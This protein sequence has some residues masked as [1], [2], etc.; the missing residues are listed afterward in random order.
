MRELSGARSPV[1]IARDDTTYPLARILDFVDRLQL[2]AT[3]DTD[4]L[5]AGLSDPV[6]MIRYWTA[7]AAQKAPRSFDLTPLLRDPNTSVRLAAAFASA[8]RGMSEPAWPVFSAA[9]SPDHSPQAR[10]E[11]LNYIT[12][13]PAPPASFRPSLEAATHGDSRVDDY[14]IRAAK[15]L[16]TP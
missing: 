14:V 10:L 16:L 3:P 15:Y 8:R 2:A 6:P 9:L 12:N 13:L 7:L 5:T 1:E 4:A 11:A